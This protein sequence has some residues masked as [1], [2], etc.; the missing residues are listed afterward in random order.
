VRWRA[1][2]AGVVTSL[3]LVLVWSVLV[4]PDRL[5]RLEPAVLL[6]IPV[7]ALVLVAVALLL[8]SRSVRL[9]AAVVG[10]V[11]GVLT[12]VRILDLGFHQVLH[13]SFNPVGDWQLL[14]PAVVA[15]R[16]SSGSAW[17][18]V[19]V[20]GAVVLVVLLVVAIGLAVVRLCA[21]ARRHRRTATGALA[22]LTVVWLVA[23]VAGTQ[24]LPGAPVAAHGASDLAVSQVRDAA[25]NL[26]DRPVFAA[27]LARPDPFASVPPDDLLTRL[28]GKD[29]VVVFV[30]SYGRVALEDAAIAPGVRTVLDDGMRSLTGAGFSAH[31]AWMTSP[32]FG[33]VSWL[34]HATLQSGMWIS[35][36][37]RH[38][39]LFAGDRL[40]LSSA[41]ARAGWRTVAD[42]PSNRDP[43]PEG[44]RFYRLDRTYDRYDVGYAGPKFGFAAMPDQ[45]TLAAF[46]RLE[47]RPGHDPVMAELDL[48]SSHE[49]WAPLPRM[50]GW[51]ELGDGS[52]FD[53][54]PA[55]GPTAADVV[56]D[57]G[58]AR[59][60]YGRSVE[61]SLEALLSWVTTR[62]ATDDDLVVVLLGDH[63]PAEV[64]TGEHAT[65]DVPVTILARDPRVL[66]AVDPWGWDDGLLPGPDAPL[67]R[68][69]VFRDR[70]LTAFGTTPEA[71]GAAG[72]V[73]PR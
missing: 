3:A 26:R 12:V 14:G 73:A 55:E 20:V 16:D 38:D 59:A 7:E 30:E 15:F 42:V 13:R 25:A 62:H 63:Q 40:T 54:M 60:Q 28:R 5:L 47:L 41:F 50:V 72:L 45:Y 21:A 70:F 58:R 61:Y 2:S 39:Q 23:A 1:L 31:S 29:V 10:V 51:D 52:V 43:W 48:V 35:S 36:Q 8:P 6:R 33:G 17:T 57:A 34:A 68:M 49:P 56:G 71:G 65:H 22:V 46:D 37:Q 27:Q 44:K 19:A 69:D 4:L 53:G 24:L 67:W 9:V 66:S 18:D 64:V 11:L 32:T